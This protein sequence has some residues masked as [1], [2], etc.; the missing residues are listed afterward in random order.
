MRR[1]RDT[2]RV[3]EGVEEKGSK[4]GILEGKKKLK[5][6]AGKALDGGLAIHAVSELK[7]KPKLEAQGLG[8]YH[9]LNPRPK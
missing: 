1:R 6:R 7:T 3:M 5:T 9:K 2:V 8:Y 4:W